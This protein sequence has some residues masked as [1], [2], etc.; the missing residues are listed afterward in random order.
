MP[1]E[2]GF[3]FLDALSVV[4]LSYGVWELARAYRTTS[5]KAWSEQAVPGA[6]GVVVA[7]LFAVM[8]LHVAG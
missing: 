6:A 3:L 8:T 7:A 2:F 4:F 5:L 1:D